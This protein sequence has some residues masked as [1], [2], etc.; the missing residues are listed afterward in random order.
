MSR[1]GITR[2]SAL[3]LAMAGAVTG[4]GL[5]T[6]S[7]VRPG[8]KVDGPPPELTDRIPAGPVSEA[9]PEEIILGFMHAGAATGEGLEVTRRYLTDALAKGWIPD[10]ET[11]VYA[12]SD[13][14]PTPLE[15]RQDAYEV[16]VRVLATIDNVGHY[17]VAPPNRWETFEFDMAQ[18]DG[19]WRI[20]QLAEG[21]GRLLEEEEVDYI[22]QDYPVHYPAVGWNALVVDQRWFPQ[23]QIATRLVRAQLGAIPDYLEDAVSTD[24]NAELAVDAVPVRSGVAEID[25]DADSVS[26]DSTTRKQLVAQLVATLTSLR[27]VTEVSITLSGNP[28]EVGVDAPLTTAEQLGFVDR[29]QTNSPTVLGRRGTRVVPVGDRLSSVTESAVRGASSAF[30]SIPESSRLIGLRADGKELAVVDAR[31]RA[32]ERYRDD[33]SV[34]TVPPFAAAMSRPCYDYGG[35]L[36]VGGLGLGREEGHR[37]WA[38]NATVDPEDLSEATPRHVP[39]PWLE[40]NHVVAA[41]TSPEGSRIAVIWEEEP[42]TGSTLEVAGIARRSNGLPTKTSPHAFRLAADLVEMVDVA[43]V[44][45]A[46]LVVIGRRDKQKGM[47]PYLVDVGGRVTALAG[48]PGTTMATTT[49]DHEDVV[50]TSPGGRVFQRLGR[51]RWFEVEPLD[52]VVVAGV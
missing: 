47:Q 25:L 10:S 7:I 29:T 23:D 28:L 5:G 24:E 43:W 32:M 48:R 26:G 52:G 49:G 17:S 44:G 18:V 19:E 36:W 42:G 9:E 38:I 51:Q 21:F 16:R 34:A 45:N 39:A 27:D 6:D 3:G 41:V 33:G 12:G 11:V 30:A 40:E 46:R 50:L 14:T 15:G 31:G 37:L 4:C 22:F 13:P 2:R 35:V 20:D 8:L 1:R